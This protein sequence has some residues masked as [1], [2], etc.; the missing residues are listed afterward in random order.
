MNF[1][2]IA[3]Q[4]MPVFYMECYTRL[5]WVKREHSLPQ[6]LNLSLPKCFSGS[7]VNRTQNSSKSSK[8]LQGLRFERW[9]VVHPPS[10]SEGLRDI[11]HSMSMVLYTR[12]IFDSLIWQFITKYD[13]CYYKMR[14]L[15][16]YKMRQKFITICVRFLLQKATVLLQNATI[17]TNCDSTVGDLWWK[18][19]YLSNT[20]T[21]MKCLGISLRK[22]G[23]NP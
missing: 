18:K 19:K 5:K 7:F 10:N 22:L 9:P 6:M 21:S 1:S 3:L 23:A 8:P 16:Y 11:Q 17:I 20:C 12:F 15:S 4:I 14:Q 2:P 13:R